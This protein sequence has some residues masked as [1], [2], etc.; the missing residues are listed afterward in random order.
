[1]S[2][3]KKEGKRAHLITHA[4]Y[5]GRVPVGGQ[6]GNRFQ[7]EGASGSYKR[8]DIV[9]EMHIR[10]E[11]RCTS[12]RAGGVAAKGGGGGGAKTKQ[13]QTICVKQMTTVGEAWEFAA[14]GED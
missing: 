1:M 14:A 4:R 10:S 3:R 2:W 5:N 6:T 8:D 11:T 13:R 7:G 9:L 12:T